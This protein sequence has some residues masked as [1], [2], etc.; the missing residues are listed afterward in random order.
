MTASSGCG[1]ESCG[2]ETSAEL[3]GSQAAVSLRQNQLSGACDA[4][5]IDFPVQADMRQTTAL[6]QHMD[7]MNRCCRFFGRPARGEGHGIHLIFPD[8]VVGMMLA[9][10]ARPDNLT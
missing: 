10:S 9:D 6:G 3:N 8:L 1:P 5:L 7:I 4:Q 2:P